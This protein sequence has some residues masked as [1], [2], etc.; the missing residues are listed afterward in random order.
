MGA[1]DRRRI[2]LVD[3][4]GLFYRAH[5]AF[6]NRPLTTSR[7]QDVG[8]TFGFVTTLL[9]LIHDE[10]ARHAAVAFD[11][12]GPTFRHERY[13]GYKATRPPMPAE[14]AA[15]VPFIER[16]VAAFGLAALA[17]EGVE[18]DD[19][20]GS[21]AR[22]AQASG[23]EVVIVSADKD[24]AQLIGAGIRQYVPSRGRDAAYWIDSDAVRAKWGVAPEQFVDFLA[25]TGDA[26]DNV[27]GVRGIG[28]KTA[29][30]LLQEHG[31]LDA[32]YGAL[33][34]IEPAGVRE[35]LARGQEV[36]HLSR[37]LVRLRTDLATPAI[38]QLTVPDPAERAP[39]R[40]LLEEFEFRQLTRRLFGGRIAPAE[41]PRSTARGA[42]TQL[43]LAA[44]ATPEPVGD[45]HAAP[46]VV[47]DRWGERYRALGDAAALAAIVERYPRDEPDRPIVAIDTETDGLDPQTARLVGVSFA[48]SP[49]DAWYVPVGHQEGQNVPVADVARL[50]APLLDDPDI[51]KA[52]QNLKFDL[53]ILGAHGIEVRGPL[54]DTMV[55]SYLR[56]PSA[57]H[58]L[59]A[60]SAE[61]LAHQKVPIETLIGSGREQVSMDQVPIE[62]VAPYACEDVDAVLRLLEPL[63]TMLRERGAQDLFER[64][65]MPLLPVL[66]AME[67]NGILV[68]V[69]LL[70]ALGR[71][72]ALQMERL[73]E[74]I[75][76]LAG[77][78]FNI[79][80]TQQ[81]QQVLFAE[82]K[83][84]PRRKT[85]TGFSTGQEVLEDLAADHPLPAKVL[86]YRQLGKLRGTYAEALPKLVDPR[87]GRIHTEFHQTV[88]ATGRL[89]SSNPNLQNIPIRTD[90][91]REIRRAFV[92]PEGWCLLSADYSQIELRILAH[93][94][95]DAD[96]LAA[97]RAGADIHRAT[98]ARVFGVPVEQVDAGMRARAKVVNFGVLYGMGAQR[99][100]REQGIPVAEAS[101]FIAEYF[102]KL[103]GVKAF[104]DRCVVAARRR[105]Y[106]E[107]LL[108]RRRYL[109]D[110]AS[111]RP[112]L[113]AA[114]ERMAVNT[115]VQGSAADLIKLAMVRVHT[116]LASEQPQARLLLQVHD[117]LVLEVPE[118]SL[119]KVRDI[120]A[121][122]M[123]GV[124]ELQVPLKVDTG[125]GRDW[126]EAHAEA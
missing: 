58:G 40:A 34:H 95:G 38:E 46:V 24:F 91:G 119:A 86:E 125:A 64:I 36:A 90:L 20:I 126:Y 44:A 30:R 43:T 55:A 113:R 98:A 78:A 39:L 25:L 65:E 66:A 102:A 122:E 51:I 31:S 114:A 99:L 35:K 53:R 23:W 18:A 14:L 16:A 37:D 56:D 5:F 121:G 79:N 1:P 70:A 68:D 4:P 49:G 41:S 42:S 27:P 61:F 7:G 82:L 120:V 6:I 17:Q 107:T 89:S 88:T 15:Q 87:T 80:S 81:L 47:Q 59:D 116:R 2:Y 108:G 54:M 3:A 85:K 96:L 94:S 115:P 109:P 63:G 106:A 118:K 74:E 11:S 97:F 100:A 67:R 83:L 57:R 62:R 72:L 28:A 71:T 117:E 19:L 101:R 112:Q 104:I 33:A 10:R 92:A 111:I 9:A 73:E 105:G 103:P 75:H 76:R 60:L 124:L 29:A 69:R 13:E 8:A 12:R 21:L 45:G 110:L 84:R 50:L 48:W 52:G 26:S 22:A 93:L 123:A 32:I 77:T